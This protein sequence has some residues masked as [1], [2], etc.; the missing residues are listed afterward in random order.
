MS[1]QREMVYPTELPLSDN[2]YGWA[3]AAYELLGFVYASGVFGRALEVVQVRIGA[4]RDVAGWR[5]EGELAEQ[6]AG[7]DSSGLTN[8]KRDLGAWVSPRDLAQLFWRAVEATDI[9]DAHG[10]P[11]WSSTASATT[12]GPSGRWRTP[13][14]SSATRRRTT[15]RSPTPMTSDDCSPV[16]AR[17]VRRPGRRVTRPPRSRRSDGRPRSLLHAGDRAGSPDPCPAALP[18]GADR[19]GAE[20]R[21]ASQPEAPRLP[22]G[23]RGSRSRA[24]S[25]I[26]RPGDAGT[27]PGAPRRDPVLAQGPGIH[28]RDPHHIGLQVLRGPRPDPRQCARRAAPALGS[29]AP[30]KDQHAPH[31]LQGHDRQSAGATLSEPVEP[32]AHGR[33]LLRGSR[34]SGRCWPRPPRPRLG[35]RRLD[36]HPGGALRDLRAQAFVRSDSQLAQRGPLGGAVASGPDGSHGPRC[37]APAPGHGWP[38]L[39]RSAVHRRD[40]CGLPGGVRRGISAGC[41]SVGARTSATA[42]WSRRWR[43]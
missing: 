26:G 42:P 16:P 10:V 38:R 17:G 12:P 24:G 43:T 32:R 40:P 41:S 22:D 11:G 25:G 6:N 39:P 15:P 1:R 13:G 30:G 27:A 36:P 2:F 21:R 31:R 29:R 3:K 34:G 19:G 8:F 4:P 28:R 7:P 23:D 37:S 18:G 14:G 9:A 33:R 20:P 35:W 5:Y